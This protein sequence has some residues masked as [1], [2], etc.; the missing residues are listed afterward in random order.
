VAVAFSP[1]GKTLAA[2]GSYRGIR[3]WEVATGRQR[4]RFVGRAPRIRS[5]AFAADGRTLAAG[6][7]QDGQPAL[8]ELWDLTTGWKRALLR[9]DADAV[10]SVAFTPDGRTLAAAEGPDTAIRLWD[11]SALGGGAPSPAPRLSDGQLEALWA[12]LAAADAPRAYRAIWSLTAAA[13]QAV[14]WLQRRLRPV[15]PADPRRV[16][17]L[18]ADLESDLFDAREKAFQELKALGESAAP[19]LQNVRT[20]RLPPEARRRVEQLLER[21]EQPGGSPE[22]LRA[23]RAIEVLEHV[24]NPEARRVLEQLAGGM[25]EARVTQDAKQSL[26]RLGRRAMCPETQR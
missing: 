10:T 13:P 16:A 21:L 1:D 18:I 17:Q 7:W 2:G 4:A 22:S 26:D 9:G 11:V 19:P 3:L 23:L 20:D 24:A 8:V 14:P 25:S 15:A 12:D 5:L 6:G